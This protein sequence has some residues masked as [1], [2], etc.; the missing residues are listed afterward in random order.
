MRN[1]HLCKYRERVHRDITAYTLPHSFYN[2]HDDDNVLLSIR[3]EPEGSRD[4]YVYYL[5]NC[6]VF[7]GSVAI[8][9]KW[10]IYVTVYATIRLRF[11]FTIGDNDCVLAG[12]RLILIF[13]ETRSGFFLHTRMYLCVFIIF[14][15]IYYCHRYRAFE[16]IM[17]VYNSWPYTYTYLF[18][19]PLHFD[20][21]DSNHGFCVH[22]S[23]EGT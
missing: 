20:L 4:T 5:E 10:K 21:I 19:L 8:P 1:D 17:Y 11:N 7:F 22:V 2:S 18:F 9:S 3:M 13:Q 12:W 14:H 6:A 15:F 23:Y 16:V